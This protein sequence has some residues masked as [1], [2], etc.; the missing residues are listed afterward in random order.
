MF[1]IDRGWIVMDILSGWLSKEWMIFTNGGHNCDS[2]LEAFKQFFDPNPD[3]W[4][5]NIYFRSRSKFPRK[6]LGSGMVEFISNSRRQKQVYFW[7]L[8]QL[9]TE[10]VP[11]K[12]K[13]RSRHIGIQL[14]S[15]APW[16]ET[17]Q[18]SDFK[19]VYWSISMRVPV[20]NKTW[21]LQASHYAFRIK[22]R[23]GY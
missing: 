17:I 9:G 5:H 2:D 21:H 7:V 11:G 8:Q 20:T 13:L 12:V 4:R 19:Y 1:Q 23:T 3:L 6:S 22:N 10:H 18:V 14:L 16:S 15:P